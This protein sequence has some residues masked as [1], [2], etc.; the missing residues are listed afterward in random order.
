MKKVGLLLLSASLSAGAFADAFYLIKDGKLGDGVT[1]NQWTSPD[2]IS[3]T[4]MTEGDGFLAF[5]HEG[6]YFDGEFLIDESKTLTLK[7]KNL[8]IEY[9]LPEEAMMY[10]AELGA[11]NCPEEGKRSAAAKE[12]ATLIFSADSEVEGT[13]FNYFEE[14]PMTN[15]STVLVDG[16]FNPEAAKGYI[17]YNICAFARNNNPVKMVRIGYQR[18]NPVYTGGSPAVKIKNLYYAEPEGAQPFYACAFDGSNTWTETC[19]MFAKNPSTGDLVAYNGLSYFQDEKGMDIIGDTKGSYAITYKLL[20]ENGADNWMGSDGSAYPASELTHSLWVLSPAD[21]SKKFKDQDIVIGFTDLEIPS[22]ISASDQYI[23]ISAL[24]K[25]EPSSLAE[26][27]EDETA[28]IPAVVKFDVDDA[29]YSAFGDS[30][31]R[32]L[33]VK[34]EGKVAI[35]AGAKKVSV[36]FK[37]HPKYSYMVDNLV[38][39]ASYLNSVAQVNGDSKSLSIYPNPVVEAISFDGVES[40]ESVKIVSMNGAAV[41]C[42][43]VDGKV[44]VSNLAAGEYV[45][46][47][48]NA[49]SGKFI[50][51]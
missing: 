8:Y 36:L 15:V 11:V 33:W 1:Y 19:A 16:K 46:I 13:T 22:T 42:A 44:N 29:E 20:Y 17:K 2:G 47:V 9:Q 41:E 4:I 5:A 14:T 21:N 31:I 26:L 25:K 18:E 30:I 10:N 7:G 32:G 45:I 3:N 40:I 27:V 6:Q 28:K 48:N 23:Y 35:P 34:E 49:I 39:S 24:V 43:V 12:K 50:K 38:L 51:K 37:A